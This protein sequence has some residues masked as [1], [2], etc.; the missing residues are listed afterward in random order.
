MKVNHHP[1]ISPVELTNLQ[2]NKMFRYPENQLARKTTSHFLHK[3]K[4]MKISQTSQV[5]NNLLDK[6][7]LIN[8]F[9]IEM[10]KSIKFQLKIR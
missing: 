3:K 7:R 1:R 4:D 8:K 5:E 9:R 6:V 2:I 10:F